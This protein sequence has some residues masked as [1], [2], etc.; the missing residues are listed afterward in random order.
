MGRVYRARDTQLVR[1]VAVKVLP[2]AFATDTDSVQR[3][4]QE[5][6]ATAALNHPGVV[7][8]CD[9]G[10]Q[11]GQPYLVSELLEGTTLRGRLDTER[12]PVRQAV[13]FA[14]QIADALAAAHDKGIVH[15]DLTPEN[16]FITSQDRIKIL[17]FGLA[18]LTAPEPTDY[19]RVDVTVANSVLGTP[20]YM[21]PE[22]ARGQAADHRAAIFSFGCVLYEMLQG[23]RAFAGQTMADVIGAILKES[24]AALTSSVERPL[25]PALVCIVERC[26]TKDPSGRF[27]STSD[28]AFALRGLSEAGTMQPTVAENPVSVS[29]STRVRSRRMSWR[30]VA[31]A[32]G[33]LAL[34]GSSVSRRGARARLR[35]PTSSSSWCRH[36]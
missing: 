6:R 32:G 24:P 15:R 33:T 34:A 14:T 27:Q 30:T 7:A 18:K 21:P 16:V 28:L 3:F 36:R 8:L 10:V 26:L 19:T 1:T 4:E 20:S 9:V 13:D 31:L 5:A 22:Q 25:P 35:P 12:L 17:D 29:E 2:P 23:H 11:D